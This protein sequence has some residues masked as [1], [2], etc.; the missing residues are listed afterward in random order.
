MNANMEH[1]YPVPLPN[2]GYFSTTLQILVSL[3]NVFAIV[4]YI[5]QQKRDYDDWQTMVTQQDSGK[6]IHF[7]K[8]TTCHHFDFPIISFSL[9]CRFW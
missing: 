2:W 4:S 3:K 9:Y 8:S 1:S 6:N 5:K 7:Q